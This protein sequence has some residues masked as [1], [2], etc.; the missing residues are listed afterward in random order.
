MTN[1]NK[2][3]YFLTTLLLTTL[4]CMS[5]MYSNASDI[6]IGMFSKYKMF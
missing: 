2:G 5:G 1:I 4:Y 3:K 6:Q